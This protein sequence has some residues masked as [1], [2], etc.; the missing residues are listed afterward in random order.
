MAQ[1]V[2]WEE[3]FRGGGD[4]VDGIGE[5]VGTRGGLAAVATN[6]NRSGQDLVVVEGLVGGMPRPPEHVTGNADGDSRAVGGPDEHGTKAGCSSEA[7]ACSIGGGDSRGGAAD[8]TVHI[9]VVQGA[10]PRPPG[11]GVPEQM[12]PVTLTHLSPQAPDIVKDQGRA[13][14]VAD[15]EFEQTGTLTRV[16]S[17]IEK[18]GTVELGPIASEILWSAGCNTGAGAKVQG[19]TGAVVDARSKQD[20]VTGQD[21]S[22][23]GQGDTAEHDTKFGCKADAGGCGLAAAGAT[24]PG[25][26]ADKWADIEDSGDESYCG[27]GGGNSRAMR[28]SST[29]GAVQRLIEAIRSASTDLGLMRYSYDADVELSPLV[30]KRR[31]SRKDREIVK[32]W[33]NWLVPLRDALATIRE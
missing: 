21:H 16:S 1:V 5:A 25:G 12:L 17:G 23:S 19:G 31:L 27:A 32:F 10:M 6:G 30:G 4:K 11:G 33:T 2:A 24:S 13:E 3:A 9:E 26:G 14:A 7:G 28:L 8:S 20:R 29:T 18:V 22:S 15:G